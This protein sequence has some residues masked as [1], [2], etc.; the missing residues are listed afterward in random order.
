MPHAAL[1]PLRTALRCSV[2]HRKIRGVQH[3][4]FVMRRGGIRR[5]G[6]S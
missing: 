5:D 4:L 2:L 3:S 6:R 1:R